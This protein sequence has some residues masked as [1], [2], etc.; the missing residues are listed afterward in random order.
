MKITLKEKQCQMCG[1]ECEPEHKEAQHICITGEKCN[2]SCTEEKL[3]W[4]CSRCG[5]VFKER[6]EDN[7]D[8]EEKVN[9]Q[10][11]IRLGFGEHT[12]Q[13]TIMF[14]Q[15]AINFFEDMQGEFALVH[16]NCEN[17][18]DCW[19]N[20]KEQLERIKSSV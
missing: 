9:L 11:K 17:F 3:E 1:G 6:A 14:L 10:R 8:N 13:D 19:K 5:Y 7:K 4:T 2:K 18:E 15:I 20:V 12:E 16:T